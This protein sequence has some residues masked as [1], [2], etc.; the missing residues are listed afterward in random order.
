MKLI[1]QNCQATIAKENIN[2]Q[3]G[4]A[5][6]TQCHEFFRI[7]DYLTSNEELR[8]LPQPHYSKVNVIRG[9]GETT[10][11][12]PSSGWTGT[13][14]FFLVFTTFWNLITWSFV[15]S[16]TAPLLMIIPFCV[17]G[18]ITFFIFLFML[19]GNT[20]VNVNLNQLTVKWA[21]Y[22]FGYTRTR[23]TK[24]L[25]R[26]TEDV[27]YSKNYQPVYGV[28]LYFKDKGKI[29]FGSNLKEEERKWIIG[30]LYELKTEMKVN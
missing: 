11:V 29:K 15:F 27:V 10:F 6:C 14:I 21:L 2:L 23:N 4:I 26:I 9:R 1:C 5:N 19:K 20:T 28:G 12:I 8:R 30:E 18:M 3:E 7:A 25:D 13:T 24:M 22:G 17:V 16:Q